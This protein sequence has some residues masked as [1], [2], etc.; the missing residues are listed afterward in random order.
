MCGSDFQARPLILHIPWRSRLPGGTVSPHRLCKPQETQAQRQA[1]IAVPQNQLHWHLLLSTS[2]VSAESRPLHVSSVL[3]GASVWPYGRRQLAQVSG[4][5]A[6]GQWLFGAQM[7]AGGRQAPGAGI[8]SAA[9]SLVSTLVKLLLFQLLGQ[10][11]S[12]AERSPQSPTKAACTD[13]RTGAYPISIAGSCGIGHPPLTTT[14]GKT[15]GP[16]LH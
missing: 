3:S 2:R 1:Q 7:G 6:S 13:T 10:F 16:G 5:Q 14:G 12:R 15:P 9:W 4:A 11:P 8:R